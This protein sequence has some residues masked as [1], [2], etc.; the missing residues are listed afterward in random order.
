MGFDKP[1]VTENGTHIQTRT[2]GGVA[3]GGLE[4]R[5]HYEVG[6]KGRVDVIHETI[7]DETPLLQLNEERRRNEQRGGEVLD[8]MIADIPLVAV[9]RWKSLYGFDL[10]KANL[11]D[12]Y[13][14]NLFNRL[15]NQNAQYKTWES[16]TRGGIIIR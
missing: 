10:F 8:K 4:Q 11:N 14:K 2:D 6:E 12:P 13:Q 15:L 3:N 1:L 7:Q 5:I 16:K 9:E